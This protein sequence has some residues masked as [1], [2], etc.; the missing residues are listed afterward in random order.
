MLC[1]SYFKKDLEFNERLIFSENDVALIIKYSFAECF[2]PSG[3]KKRKLDARRNEE[4]ISYSQI[5]I[6]AVIFSQYL[7]LHISQFIDDC[8]RYVFL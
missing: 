4:I 8:L 5:K 7:E 3:A 2:E 1:N 6:P